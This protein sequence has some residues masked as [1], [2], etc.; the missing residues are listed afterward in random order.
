MNDPLALTHAD[1]LG[2]RAGQLLMR[3]RK[4]FNMKMFS[5]LHNTVMFFLSLY[6]VIETITQVILKL[7][8]S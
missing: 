8:E 1:I 2:V 7:K 5:I 6:M 4:Q 3:N